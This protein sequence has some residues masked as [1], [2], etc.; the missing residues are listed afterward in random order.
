MQLA[1]G[2]SAVYDR[3]L[4]AGFFLDTF[5][6]PCCG[7]HLL[8]RSAVM[9]IIFSLLLVAPLF[10]A[11]AFDPSQQDDSQAVLRCFAPPL[12]PVESVTQQG[13]I[14]PVEDET[15]S[16]IGGTMVA[17]ME[18]SGEFEAA[19][20]VAF[21]EMR[22]HVRNLG[23]PGDTVYRQQRPMFFYTDKGDTAEGSVPDQ[24]EKIEPG[25]M[26]LA[27]GRMESLDG[28]DA[29]DNFEAAYR[30]LLQ[31]FS[32]I[33]SRL[34]MVAPIPFAEAGPAAALAAERNLVLARYRERVA[35]LGGEFDAVLVTMDDFAPEDF[36]RN[37]VDL[38][39]QGQAKLAARLAVAWGSPANSDPVLI[40][41]I[42]EK[43][44]LWDQYHRPTNWAFLFGDRQ[45]VP[46][47]RD[48]RDANRRWFIE[49]I[50]KIPALI[51]AAD[52]AI[53]TESKG[54]G[55]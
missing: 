3:K 16:L 4:V 50:Q 37:G 24:R 2:F 36:S 54:V 32:K 18:R 19:L 40:E 21:P 35:A 17:Q 30:G 27:F 48:E 55:Q 53:W 10:D 41:A 29:L 25:T 45:H 47:S 51:S 22:L 26:V 5:I 14:R 13:M 46:S 34:V 49:E 33:S 9:R 28:L 1:L 44:R 42:R 38:G 12:N 43:D 7:P 20:Q 23:W 8:A 11:A 52:S 39:A 15:I 31:G 6:S